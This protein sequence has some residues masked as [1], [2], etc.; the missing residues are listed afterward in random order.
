MNTSASVRSTIPKIAVMSALDD[1]LDPQM[2][3]S[4]KRELRLVA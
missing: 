2:M 4:I 1:S 3:S